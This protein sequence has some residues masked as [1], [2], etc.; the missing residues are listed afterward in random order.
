MN[1]E[2]VKKFIEENKDQEEVKNY[3]SGFT[4]VTPDGVNSFLETE[5]GKKLLQPKMDSYFAKGLETWKSNN[6]SKLLDE[7]FKKK[8]PE[9]NEKDLEIESIKS[10]LEAIKAEKLRESLK[11]TGLK[12]A[13]ENKLPVDLVDYFIHLDHEKGE[14][15]TLQNLNKLKETWTSNLQNLVDEKL[16]GNGFEPNTNGEKPKT[17]TL[18]QVKAMSEEEM[19]KNWD[20]VQQVLQNNK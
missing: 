10:E 13:T 9:K 7:E 2:D 16:K 14:E 1:L 12:Y 18:D 4:Q 20:T 11:N 3:I 15:L 17:F 5:E 8:F 6:L 19:L